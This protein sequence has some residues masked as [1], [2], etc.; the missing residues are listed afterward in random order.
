VREHTHE[1]VAVGLVGAGR[2]E[3]VAANRILRRAVLHVVGLGD[4]SA[5]P[6]ARRRILDE[7]VAEYRR[8]QQDEHAEDRRSDSRF[9]DDSL[10]IVGG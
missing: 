1:A 5:D 3:R 9:H 10:L 6:V 7:T 2:E 4:E 8:G